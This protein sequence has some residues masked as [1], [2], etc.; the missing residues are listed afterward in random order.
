ME[1]KQ[2]ELNS[3]DYSQIFYMIKFYELPDQ[4]QKM[5]SYGQ[6]DCN[7]EI[8]NFLISYFCLNMGYSKELV[9]QIMTAWQNN[10]VPSF[11]DIALVSIINKSYGKFQKYSS[12]LFKKF[13]YIKFEEDSKQFLKLPNKFINKFNML[14]DCSIRIY[15]A[16]AA[17]CKINNTN[18]CTKQ[19]LGTFARVSEK[20]IERHIGELIS[21]GFI[22]KFKANSKVFYT[23]KNDI[24]IRNEFTKISVNQ[25]MKLINDTNGISDGAIKVYVFLK[26][27]MLNEIFNIESHEYQKRIGA[28]TAK[29]GNTISNITT[30]LKDKGFIK[31]CNYREERFNPITQKREKILRCAYQII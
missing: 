18:V 6:R 29:K 28:M 3:I 19:S 1:E 26:Y 12:V 5:I 15:I 22:N 8:V 21:E 25:L 10:N 9:N 20:T 30:I 27:H 13:G 7:L 14:H 11:E 31:K 16:I 24:E 4:I 23:I 17:Y 2:I